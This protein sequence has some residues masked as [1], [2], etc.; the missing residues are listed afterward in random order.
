[1]LIARLR[2]QISRAT[3][4]LLELRIRLRDRELRELFRQMSRRT[5]EEAGMRHGE[6]GGVVVRVASGERVKIERFERGDGMFLLVLHSHMMRH[7]ASLA[8][9]FELI[10]KERRIPKLA[11][12]G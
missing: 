6:H 2:V 11:H 1:M 10:T 4:M 3:Q 9:D 8:V 5:E 7:D 12:E